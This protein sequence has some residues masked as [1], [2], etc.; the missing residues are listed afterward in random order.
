MFAWI[1]LIGPII[2]GI[3][4]IFTK[5][6]D[7][8]LGKKKIEAGVYTEEITSSAQ[9]LRDFHDDIA[10]RICRDIILLPGSLWV[11]SIVWSKFIERHYPDLVWAVN[12]IPE[13]IAYLPMAIMTFLFGVVAVSAYKR[14][15]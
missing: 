14:S 5:F 3:V 11:G 13:S 4:S 2:E 9:T 10:V 15:Q 12:A 1:P 8:D 6:E 7:T